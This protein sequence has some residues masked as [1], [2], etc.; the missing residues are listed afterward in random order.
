MVEAVALFLLVYWSAVDAYKEVDDCV[1]EVIHM[2]VC[3]YNAYD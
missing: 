3:M 2:Y 1:Q